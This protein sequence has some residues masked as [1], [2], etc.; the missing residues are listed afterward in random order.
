MNKTPFPDSFPLL[1]LNLILLL[2]LSLF[3]SPPIN[4][5]KQPQIQRQPL[6]QP[7]RALR[8]IPNLLAL[9]IRIRMHQR[10]QRPAVDHQPGNKSPELGGCEQVHF[11][12]GDGVRADGVVE[13]AVDAKFGNLTRSQVSVKKDT[14][15]WGSRGFVGVCTYIPSE[16]ARGELLRRLLVR[17]C[18]AIPIR[19][20]LSIHTE[21]VQ[22]YR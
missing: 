11:E 16:S 8:M 7:R 4:L 13:E 22:R 12:H 5:P 15:W 9:R 17:G 20:I 6:P 19:Q 10:T 3:Y 18:S 2:I 21:Y 14:F 1:P